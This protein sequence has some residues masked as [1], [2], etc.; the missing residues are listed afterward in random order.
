MSLGGGA[1]DSGSLSPA[2]KTGNS[3]CAGSRAT[4]SR[5]QKLK[6]GLTPFLSKHI[7]TRGRFAP[8]NTQTIAMKS[9][10][11]THQIPTHHLKIGVEMT[12]I[13]PERSKELDSIE[14]NIVGGPPIRCCWQ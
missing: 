14:V 13:A 1:L 4:F 6:G 12:M 10:E 11:R 8:W 2:H 7:D 9:G 3:S 5:T